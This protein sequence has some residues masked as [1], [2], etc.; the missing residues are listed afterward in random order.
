MSVFAHDSMISCYIVAQCSM[1]PETAYS[2]FSPRA[3]SSTRRSGS[4]KLRSIPSATHWATSG[5]QREPLGTSRSQTRFRAHLSASS[6]CRW[7]LETFS[8]Y[9]ETKRV[10]VSRCPLSGRVIAGASVLTSTR[11]DRRMGLRR[12]VLLH[13]HRSQHRGVLED[14][15]LPIGTWRVRLNS[16]HQWM[17]RT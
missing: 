10:G 4:T 14:D 6:T 15:C 1:L 8:R 3:S 2:C 9:T 16:S 17:V 13:R 5:P 11:R 7:P 12:Y